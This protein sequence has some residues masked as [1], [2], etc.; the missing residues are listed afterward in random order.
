[1]D[2]KMTDGKRKTEPCNGSI[3]RACAILDF[4]TVEENRWSLKDIARKCGI[5]STTAIPVLRALE[6]SGYL[7]RD[8]ETKLYSLGIKLLEKS[9]VKLNSLNVID[10]AAPVLR[11]LS[12]G[13]S[14]NSHLARLDA[15]D[16]IYLARYEAVVHSLSPSYVG[17][18]I[19]AYCSSLGKA[20][21]AYMNREDVRMILENT[22]FKRFTPHTMTDPETV[23]TDLSKT[24]GRGYAID[25]EEYQP[26]GYCVAVPVFDAMGTVC[27]SVSC[28]MTKGE[29]TEQRLPGLITALKQAGREISAAMGYGG[30]R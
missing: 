5:S 8:P 29:E 9:Q 19:P 10:C 14:V 7:E 21:L 22:H 18:R 15:G 11:E 2:Q 27:A 24:V 12:R 13:Y 17:K 6:V 25:D 26:G 20:I 16:V 3:L 1:M 23:L 30:K 4:F 28:S